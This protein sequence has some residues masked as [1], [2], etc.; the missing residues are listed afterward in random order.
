DLLADDLDDPE[1]EQR[2]VLAPPVG[3]LVEPRADRLLPDVAVGSVY[4]APVE[5]GLGRHPRD[6]PGSGDPHPRLVLGHPLVG[7]RLVG[8]GRAEPPRAGG[9][10]R[11]PRTGTWP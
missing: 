3:P 2:A 9:G 6:G 10:A 11:R 8:H 7:L 5:P 4:L 1:E